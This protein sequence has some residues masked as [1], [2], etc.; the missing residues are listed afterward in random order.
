MVFQEGA[1]RILQWN[2]KMVLEA[3]GGS[4]QDFEQPSESAEVHLELIGY[5]GVNYIDRCPSS[6]TEDPRFPGE[7]LETV[8]TNFKNIGHTPWIVSS[9]G[10]P[11]STNFF[12]VRMWAK[13]ESDDEYIKVAETN[14]WLMQR[15]MTI[16]HFEMAYASF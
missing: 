9:A 1:E 4:Q 5:P 2:K 13:L 11:L 6:L 15:T 12:R 10:E 14:T 3:L 7:V 8:T 16:S